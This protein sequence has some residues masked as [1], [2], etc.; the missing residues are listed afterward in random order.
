MSGSPVLYFGSE[1][2]VGEYGPG[3]RD[4]R[5][6]HI[7]GV[8]AGREGVTKEENEM[9]LGRVWKVELLDSLFS[10]AR[11]PGKYD[12]TVPPT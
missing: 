12:F 2:I 3:G 5:M 8:Y 11:C 9:T 10:D 4:T 1:D 6:P 7:V